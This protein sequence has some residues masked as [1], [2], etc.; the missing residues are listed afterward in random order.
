[1]FLQKGSFAATAQEEE[2]GDDFGW[3]MNK[4]KE[5]YKNN[6]TTGTTT[7]RFVSARIWREVRGLDPDLGW[8][9]RKKRIGTNRVGIQSRAGGGSVRLGEEG[10]GNHRPC[11]GSARLRLVRGGCS[12][13]TWTVRSSR[14]AQSSGRN[15]SLHDWII[16]DV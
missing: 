6:Y 5:V 9:G 7:S 15:G 4:E 12:G 14:V 10:E 13:E 11:C 2:N 1:L 3:I 16:A 8:V